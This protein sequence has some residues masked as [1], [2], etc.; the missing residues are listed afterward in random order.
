MTNGHDVI[1][2]VVGIGD[3]AIEKVR[4]AAKL[5]DRKANAEMVDDLVGRGKALVSKV[6]RA[7][8]T[9][10]AFQ[11]TKVAR[12]QIKAATTSVTKAV[13]S[14]AR[15]TRSAAGKAVKAS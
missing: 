2:A 10:Q 5:A 15:A 4:G 7:Q 14:N 12:S 1:Y 6:K 13:R 9:K 8:P 11:Q 3:F